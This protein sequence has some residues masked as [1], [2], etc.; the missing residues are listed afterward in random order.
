MGVLLGAGYNK[1]DLI[2]C[3]NPVPGYKSRFFKE[4]K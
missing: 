2:N 4:R 1:A 3:T